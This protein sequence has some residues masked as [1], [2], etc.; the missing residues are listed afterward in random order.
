MAPLRSRFRP[1][2]WL[3]GGH[4]QTLW[5]PLF[6]RIA[7]PQLVR[8]RIELP[9]GDFVDLDHSPHAGSQD[10]PGIARL[11]VVILHGLEGSADSGYVRGLIHACEARGWAATAFQF[12][13]CSGEPNRLPRSYHSGDTADLARVLRHMAERFPNRQR[14]AVGYSL[15]GNVL[16]K[17][18]GETGPDA[19]LSSAAAVSVPFDLEQAALHLSQGASRLYQWHLVQAMRQKA[20]AK[21]ER[22]SPVLSQRP[23]WLDRRRIAALRTFHDFDQAITAPLHGFRNVFDYYRSSSCRQYLSKIAI[24]TLLIH[25]LDDPFYPRHEIPTADEGSPMIEWE[26]T[27]GGGHVGFYGREGHGPAG[28]WL[29]SRIPQYFAAQGL[30]TPNESINLA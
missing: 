6:R 7:A 11:H 2:W 1:S 14:V 17:Y 20:L 3:G 9:D 12:R 28:Y 26:L 23:G 15:G 25:A 18:L 8:E 29:E 30:V 24:P 4:R 13:G 21:Y 22:M 5:P 19:L 16:L 27:E 10:V